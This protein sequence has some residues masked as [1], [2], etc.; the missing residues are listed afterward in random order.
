MGCEEGKDSKKKKKRKNQI[1][2]AQRY[3]DKARRI[4]NHIRLE[5][6]LLREVGNMLNDAKQAR[7]KT[8]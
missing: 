4:W 8:R 3:G 6:I 1:E 2:E 5:T 7:K